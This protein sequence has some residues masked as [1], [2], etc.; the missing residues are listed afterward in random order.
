MPNNRI[1]YACQAVGIAKT[2]ATPRTLADTTFRMMQGVQSV[3]INTNFTLEQVF[4]LGQVEL[5]ANEEDIADIE[6]TIEK[7][8]DGKPLLYLQSVGNV[9]K[10]NVVDAANSRCDVYL[11]VFNDSVASI[12][13]QNAGSVVMCS[14]MYVSSVSYTYP[15]DGQAT[16]SVTLVGNDKFWNDGYGIVGGAN[17]VKTLFGTPTAGPDD[18]DPFDGNDL[19]DD[20]ATGNRAGFAPGSGVVR[21]ARVDIAGSTIPE[22]VGLQQNAVG[23]KGIQSITINADFGRENQLEL[24]RFGPYNKYA[25]FPFEVTCEFEVN[26]VSGDLVSVSGAGKNLTNRS[27]VVKDL[28]GTVIDLG[29][30]NKLTSVAYTGG[31]TGGGIATVTYSYSTYNDFKVNGGGDYW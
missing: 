26:A 11:A 1:F 19:A 10:T 14:G 27:I 31:D 13:G 3:G 6:V 23:T 28:A 22:E 21:R 7:V 20:P 30:K 25:T 8:I 18:Q 9:G 16:E 4:E 24:G 5:Y 17:A 29:T 2:G 12:S 15:V